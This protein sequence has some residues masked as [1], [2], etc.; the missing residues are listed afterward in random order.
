MLGLLLDLSLGSIH[1]GIHHKDEVSVSDDYY[2]F[3]FAKMV[4]MCYLKC[5]SGGG[6]WQ[7]GYA[8]KNR[9]VGL[10]LLGK[11]TLKA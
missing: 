2:R 5:I 8:S 11:P 7:A 3:I 1:M 4:L 6:A 9:L 10:G